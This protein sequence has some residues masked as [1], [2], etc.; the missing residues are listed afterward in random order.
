[1]MNFFYL[2]YYKYS[3]FKVLLVKSYLIL[4]KQ[5]TCLAHSHLLKF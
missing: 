3:K 4:F 5:W 1:M 2:M